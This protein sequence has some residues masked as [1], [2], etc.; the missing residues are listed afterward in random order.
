LAG[1]LLDESLHWVEIQ[2]S[3]RKISMD[4]YEDFMMMT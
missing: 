1:Y 2:A 3:S 4:G